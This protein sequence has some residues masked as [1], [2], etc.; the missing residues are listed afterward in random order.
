MRLGILVLMV[1]AVGL[2]APTIHADSVV[3]I[4][5]SN[6]SL[7]SSVLNMSFEYDATLNEIVAGTLAISFSGNSLGSGF[8]SSFV[9][10]E[11]F[12][13][14]DS[15]GD[16]LQIDSLEFGFL[17]TNGAVFPAPATGS[18]PVQFVDTVCAA[19]T[20]SGFDLC[21]LTI[22]PG[23][24]NGGSGSLTVSAIAEPGTSGMLA[25]GVVAL[26]AISIRS[27]FGFRAASAQFHD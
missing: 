10:P 19:P 1:L 17:N 11:V 24:T 9:S 13:F 20:A 15:E 8:S 16:L 23:F 21:A 14:S 12:N 5:A 22:G 3:L 4:D 26:L 25:I 27:R 6:V 2:S 7:G 18:Y